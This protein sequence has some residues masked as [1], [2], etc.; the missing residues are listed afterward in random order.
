M[1]LFLYLASGKPVLAPRAPDTR[2]LLHHGEN[3]ILVEPGDTAGAVAALRS[4]LSDDAGR[5]RLGA[6]GAASVADLTWDARAERIER[7]LR[8]RLSGQLGEPG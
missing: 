6:A 1:K 3:A 8:E 2:D 5:E 4:L 7:F